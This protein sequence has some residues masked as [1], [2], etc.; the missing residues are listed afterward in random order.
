MILTG[1]QI[2]EMMREE[3]IVGA[4]P[5]LVE[6]TSLDVRLQDKILK[7]TKAR[8]QL[9]F[10]ADPYNPKMQHFEMHQIKPNGE[11]I[12]PGEF[13]LA[14]TIEYLKLPNNVSA[15]FMLKSSIARMGLEHSKSGWIEAGFEGTITLE[16][17]VVTQ[18]HKF[19]IYAGMPIGQI[20]FHKHM[21]TGELAYD[22]R[23]RYSGQKHPQMSKGVKK[24]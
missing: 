18:Y 14:A 9:H 1:H 21:P 20:V 7:E 12:F 13:F 19:K 5:H 2:I 4:L 6:T 3:Q 15:E 10:H 17:K 24:P 22:K 11:F 23:G 8:G 16:L